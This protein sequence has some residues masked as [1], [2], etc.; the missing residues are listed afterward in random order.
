MIVFHVYM[1]CEVPIGYTLYGLRYCVGVDERTA[2]QATG[3]PSSKD[4][5]RGERWN[6]AKI[7]QD[8]ALGNS[9]SA[10]IRDVSSIFVST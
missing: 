2:I 9:Y 10:L 3:I 5:R 6:L 8:E 4:S 1:D 7:E